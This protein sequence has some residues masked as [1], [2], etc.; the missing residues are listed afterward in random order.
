MKLENQLEQICEL[1]IN[2]VSKLK[3]LPIDL[4]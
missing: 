2:I 1:I 3:K 4:G